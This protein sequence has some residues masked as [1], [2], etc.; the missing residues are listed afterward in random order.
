MMKTNSTN[1]IYEDDAASEEDI[2]V[3]EVIDRGCSPANQIAEKLTNHAP[4][5]DACGE[6]SGT[7]P[8]GRP[9]AHHH[10]VLNTC[11]LKY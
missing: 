3:I 11:M 4:R 5:C 2:E 1:Y 9:G 10:T 8:C 6:P 7:K